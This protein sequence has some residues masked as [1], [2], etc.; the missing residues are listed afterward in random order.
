MR[1]LFYCNMISIPDTVLAQNRTTLKIHQCPFLGNSFWQRN[2]NFGFPRCYFGQL[3]VARGEMNI[4]KLEGKEEEKPR[5][6]WVK[7]G[8]DITEDQKRA[9]SQI[10][11]KL[12]NRCKAFIKQ[13]ICFSPEKGSLLELLAAWVKSMKPA[14]ADWLLVLKEMSR[15]EHPLYLEVAQLALSEETFEAGI[16]DYTKIIHGYATRNQVQKAEN[17]LLAMKSKGFT[18]DQVTLTALVHMYSK[19]GDLN[20]AGNTFEDMKLLGVALDKR[21]Y[22]SMIMAYIR[23]GM[24]DEGE[25]LLK[26]M[27]AEDK[28]AGREVYKALLRAYST[29]GDSKGAQRVFNAIQLAGIIPDAKI[30]ALL[31]NAYVVAGKNT[32]ACIAFEN[33]KRSGIEPNDKCVALV[34]SVYEKENKLNRALEFLME[35]ERDGFLVGKESSEIMARWFRR[36][37]VLEEVELVLRDYALG[38]AK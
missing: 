22:G 10:S 2:L 4:E 9:I 6:R 20:M 31:L 37:G 38:M 34:L 15:L 1:C 11:P 13:I 17:V 21:S 36:L 5:F 16:R 25:S 18:C 35:L 19:A 30:C 7:I 23:A 24:L 29:N 32:E 8:P 28:Y 3:M 26:E 14:R 33:L 12:S 27:E